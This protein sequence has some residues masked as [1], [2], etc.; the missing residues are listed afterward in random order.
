MNVS[1]AIR[2]AVVF[3]DIF[4]FSNVTSIEPIATNNPK[5]FILY[6][7]YPNPFNPTTTIKFYIPV[8]QKIE[9]SVYNIL[10]QKI[11]SLVS[12]FQTAGTNSIVWDGKNDLGK[13]VGSGIYFYST[14]SGDITK[15]RK[16]IFLK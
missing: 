14:R 6:Q 5:E 10:G 2:T 8:A 12:G 11:R 1:F 15:N 13:L 16:M 7:N 4:E 3:E 9:L